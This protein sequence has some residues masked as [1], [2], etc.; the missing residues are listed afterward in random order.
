MLTLEERTGL[1]SIIQT[2]FLKNSY[3][4]ISVRREIKTIRAEVNEIENIKIREKQ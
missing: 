4:R 3:L 2:S 1:K